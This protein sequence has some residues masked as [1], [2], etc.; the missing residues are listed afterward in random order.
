VRF[1]IAAF[2]IQA[3]RGNDS[4]ALRRLLDARPSSVEIDVAVTVDGV[5]I[6]S[7][8]T[9]ASELE[10]RPSP[11]IGRPWHELTGEDASAL[12]RLTFA[13]A[14]VL[15]AGTPVVAEAKSIPGESATVDQFVQALS[16]YLG[17][18]VLISFDEHVLAKARRKL[19][20]LATTF[21]FEEP[22]RIATGAGTVG[23]RSDLEAAHA[24]GVRVVPWT[25]ND[26][27]EMATLIDLGVDGLV[28]DEP[29]LARAVCA[30]RV[31]LAVA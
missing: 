19:P 26:P 2:E 15:A 27:L 6:C 23:P 14:L 30:G 20:A 9:V 17:A 8:E 3:H 28:T 21:L 29:A 24:L 5:A 31:E 25:V 22:L 16:P 1:A 4:A 12:G 10:C 7:H 18:I 13:Q 11:L